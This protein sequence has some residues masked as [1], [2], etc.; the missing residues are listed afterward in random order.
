MLHPNETL[1]Q[2]VWQLPESLVTCLTA[3]AAVEGTQ[4][5]RLAARMLAACLGEQEQT[6]AGRC[7]LRTGLRSEGPMPLPMQQL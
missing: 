2:V 1:L 3:Q 6:A 4:P 7:S 5:E